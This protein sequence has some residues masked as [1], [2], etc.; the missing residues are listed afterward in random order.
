MNNGLVTTGKIKKVLVALDLTE[1]DYEILRYLKYFTNHI[2]TQGIHF[3]HA[4]PEFDVLRSPY[5][6]EREDLREAWQLNEVA[7]E[8]IKEE[9]FGTFDES[10]QIELSFDTLS[11]DPL[12]I[13]LDQAKQHEADLLVVGDKDR[14][15]THG[16]LVKNIVRRSTCPVLFVPEDPE[17][18]LSNIL[19]PIDFSENS[20]RALKAAVAIGNN[21]E[22]KANITCF[23]VYDLPD[24]S[25]YF[26][27]RPRGEFKSMMAKSVKEAFGKFLEK[28]VPSYEGKID[29]AL[30]ER[31]R[32][33]VSKYI[34]DYADDHDFGLIVLGAKG[35]SLIER[36]LIGSV[37]E[38]LLSHDEDIPIL[39]VK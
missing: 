27:S 37:T 3:L 4:L 31:L 13:I 28:H 22:E 7:W 29:L 34:L 8:A 10:D 12:G 17:L 20:A 5:F 23:N 35:H 15:D 2:S 38:S 26:V 11:G 21:L 36:L 25:S 16:V 14:E 19:V 1:M 33:S 9:T 6:Q 32:P 39:V 30:E 24:V 18:F